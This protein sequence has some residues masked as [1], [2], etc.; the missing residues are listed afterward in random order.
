MRGG[1]TS[2]LESLDRMRLA[3]AV[4]RSLLQPYPHHQPAA[5]NPQSTSAAPLDGS[6]PQS[7][8]QLP[9]GAPTAQPASNRE[10]DGTVKTIPLP[11]SSS[12]TYPT[13]PSGRKL[14]LNALGVW[15]T[16][17]VTCLHELASRLIWTFCRSKYVREVQR[18]ARSMSSA[19]SSAQATPQDAGGKSKPELL[20]EGGGR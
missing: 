7:A 11:G 5:T 18:Q 12:S 10:A 17:C 14:Y 16:G 4:R 1:V 2:D 8:C 3:E 15:L 9:V 20:V 19:E 13:L 6:A